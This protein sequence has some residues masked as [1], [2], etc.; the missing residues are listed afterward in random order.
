MLL[1]LEQLVVVGRGASAAEADSSTM[2]AARVAAMPDR[3]MATP[4]G[5]EGSAAEFFAF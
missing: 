1:V 3:R 4:F 5:P 2:T